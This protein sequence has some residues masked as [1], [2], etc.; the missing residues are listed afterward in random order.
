MKLDKI[1][2]KPASPS[3][4]Y[5][6]ACGA[7]HALDLAGERWALLVMRELLLGPKRFSDLRADLPGI[8]ANVLQQRLEGLEATS[9]VQRRKLP[10]P[11]SAQVYEL[12]EWGYQSEPIFQAL[13]NWAARS[14][15]H[16]PSLPI[17][18]VS[19]LLSFR[20]MFSPHLAKGVEARI[21]FHFNDGDYLATIAAGRIAV[22]RAPV[23]KA[24]ASFSG[25]AQALAA[26]VYGGQTLES[27]EKQG[28]LR[29]AGD[30]KLAK[31]FLGW[32]PLPEKAL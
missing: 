32:F 18:T 6:D 16:D 10:P 25:T 13:G 22:A 28:A 29:V 12:T 8:S 4:R 14:P 2:K 9:I 24:D 23:D 15:S 17:S 30:R 21:G 1:T 5:N 19:V 20:T 31:R 3:R 27:L 26:A 11:A 7:A